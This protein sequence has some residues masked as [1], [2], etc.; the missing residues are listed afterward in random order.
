MRS[1]KNTTYIFFSVIFL[2]LLITACNKD[3]T[4]EIIEPDIPPTPEETI[5]EPE[6]TNLLEDNYSLQIHPQD[7][8]YVLAIYQFQLTESGS[9]E[10]GAVIANGFKLASESADED[11][12]LAVGIAYQSGGYEIILTEQ[13]DYA[14]YYMGELSLEDFLAGITGQSY[15]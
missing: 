2:S 12:Q 3:K 6:I 8:N 1:F 14:S 15:P 10:W 9:G 13:Q 7:K 4:D 11:D 5:P